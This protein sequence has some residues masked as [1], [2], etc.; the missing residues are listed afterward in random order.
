[1]GHLLNPHLPRRQMWG[2]DAG[3]QVNSP[4]Q[5]DRLEWATRTEDELVKIEVKSGT[6]T[7]GSNYG[8]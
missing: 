4:T 3:G 8:K 6:Y 2:T 7:G 1:M 5:A